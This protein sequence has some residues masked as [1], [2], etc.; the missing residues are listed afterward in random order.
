MQSVAGLRNSLIWVREDGTNM[1]LRCQQNS[2][3]CFHVHKLYCCKCISERG[4]LKEDDKNSFIGALNQKEW[5]LWL[6]FIGE[7]PNLVWD[8]YTAVL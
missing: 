3:D 7:S 5:N 1:G 4:V 8:K 2:V 6:I